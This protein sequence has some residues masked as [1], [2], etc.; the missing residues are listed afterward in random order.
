MQQVKNRK[1]A[2]R[3][4]RCRNNKKAKSQKSEDEI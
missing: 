4:A 3:V 1:N 2:V